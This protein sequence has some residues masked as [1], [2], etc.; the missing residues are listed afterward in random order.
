MV[1]RTHTI[2]SLDRTLNSHVLNFGSASATL[3][4]GSAPA[5]QQAATDIKNMPAG[6]RIEIAGHT[7]NQGDTNANLALSQ[8][9][10]EAVR[11]ALVRDGVDPAEVSAKG[12]GDTKPIASNE[13]ANGRT[14][15]RR[16]EFNQVVTVP[17]N[18]QQY[19]P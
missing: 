9:R 6:T 12:Y 14:Q 3:P 1:T 17:A 19:H 15:N 4:A 8:Q 2:V 7:D 10:A 13:T 5:L 11:D 18:E 16:I